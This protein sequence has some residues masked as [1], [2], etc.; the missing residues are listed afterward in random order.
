M[1]TCAIV[2]CSSDQYNKLWGDNYTTLLLFAVPNTPYNNS[3]DLLRELHSKMHQLLPS[4]CIPDSVILMDTLPMTD[5]GN[6]VY[7]Q[8]SLVFILIVL[9]KVDT[10]LL[11]LK[12]NVKTLHNERSDVQ[13]DHFTS[14]ES[15]E[16]WI[17]SLAKAVGVDGW[18]SDVNF[19]HCGGDSFQLVQIINMLDEHLGTKVNIRT[20]DQCT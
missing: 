15:V 5:H 18:K 10:S 19:T 3:D 17:A 6:N 4:Y 2:S 13:N 7:M 12:Y 14:V 11:L 9:G 20:S 16:L 1:K 8:Y